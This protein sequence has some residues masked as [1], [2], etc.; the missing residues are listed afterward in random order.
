MSTDPAASSHSL[1]VFLIVHNEERHLADCLA[2]VADL[3]GKACGEIVVLDDGSQDSTVEIARRA[4]AR[5]EFR[6]FDDFGHQ[7]QA[8]LDMTTGEWVLSIDADEQVTPQ[9]ASEIVAVVSGSGTADGYWMRRE[10][11]Y[12]G[13]RLRFGG[14]GGDWVLR[15][16]R[17]SRVRFQLL[18]IHEHM[19]VNGRTAR[20][21]GSLRHV[22]YRTLA[23]H[24]AQLDRYTQMVADDKRARGKTFAPWHLLRIPLEIWSRLILRLGLLDGR[25]GIIWAA[26]AGFYSFL[27]YAKIW[28]RDDV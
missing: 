12:L 18:P 13:A 2:S 10:L 22:K 21:R 6:P 20:L 27:K 25:P 16:A 1:S 3:V 5:V 15:L 4:G 24:V 28:R 26:M 7:K 19:I 17:R 23:E 11:I 9:L 8:A 14:T